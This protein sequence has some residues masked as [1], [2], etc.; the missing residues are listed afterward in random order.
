[1]RDFNA[2]RDVNV[3]GDLVIT[4]NS[5]QLGKPFVQCTNDELFSERIHRKS[6]L[7]GERKR[8]F[9][10]VVLVWVVLGL[11]LAAFSLVLFYKGKLESSALSLGFAGLAIG[12][13]PIK[14]I[15]EPNE[16]E[17]RQHGALKEIEYIL[18]ERGSA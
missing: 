2:G 8:K 4:D 5:I 3:S 12:L 14:L 18:R 9:Q 16:F 13:A 15:I 7:R 10:K 6:L 1:M 11:A 17:A